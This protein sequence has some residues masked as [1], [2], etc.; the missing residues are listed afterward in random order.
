VLE[1]PVNESAPADLEETY[2]QPYPQPVYNPV[3]SPQRARARPPVLNFGAGGLYTPQKEIFAK[4]KAVICNMNL[5]SD[6]R[7]CYTVLH[8]TE[9]FMAFGEKSSPILALYIVGEKSTG[10]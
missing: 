6:L 10:K 5:P 7:L 1:L 2:P 8:I 4:V 3:D 9:L